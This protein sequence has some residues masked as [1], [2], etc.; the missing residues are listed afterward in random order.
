MITKSLFMT[1]LRSDDILL[2]DSSTATQVRNC[3]SS[4]SKLFIK[5]NLK[6]LERNFPRSEISFPNTIFIADS[7]LQA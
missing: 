3:L 1:S 7:Q 5:R 4:L 2:L 6:K